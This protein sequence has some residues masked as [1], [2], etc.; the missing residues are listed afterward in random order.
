M[1]ILVT[2][3]CGYVGRHLLPV[4]EGRGH[5][6]DGI[7]ILDGANILDADGT[8]WDVE[9]TRPDAVVHLAALCHAGKSVSDPAK[10]WQT[11]A[12]G[13]AN[14]LAGLKAVAFSGRFVLA[15]TLLAR[16][17][18]SSPYAASKYAC[19]QMVAAAARAHGFSAV[20]LRIAN[21]AGGSDPTPGRIVPEACRA[22]RDH[23]A[24]TLH[25]GHPTPDGTCLRDYVHVL[26]V[27]EAVCAA[28]DA[29]LGPREAVTLDIGTGAAASVTGVVEAVCR[30][31]GRRIRTEMKAG[32]PG[33]VAE[34][35]ADVREAERVLDWRATRT[36]GE[37][38]Q[39]AWE[40]SGG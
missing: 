12:G 35:C 34:V 38:C 36:L 25:G 29:P 40:A 10:Y 20:T 21:V 5:A 24:L 3:H 17:P 1:R 28:L 9:C 11:N 14:L 32:R 13:T 16:H 27:A 19:E 33:D 4:L 31:S 2:G 23:S 37:I 26:D 7:D 30:A 18:E 6:I 8:F 22:A 39:S 15:S